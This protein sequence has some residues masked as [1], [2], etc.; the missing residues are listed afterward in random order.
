MLF[1]SALGLTV[2]ETY[3]VGNAS[4]L[5]SEAEA[6]APTMVFLTLGYVGLAA[7]VIAVGGATVSTGAGEILAVVTVAVNDI[8]KGHLK[9]DATDR[10]MLLLSR[11]GLFFI[12]GLV[13]AVVIYWRA[14]GFGFAGMYQA[15]GIAF[16]SAVIPLIMATFW[17]KTNRNAVFWATI[18]GSICGTTYWIHTDMDLLWGVVASNIIVMAVSALIAIPWTLIQI[19]RAHV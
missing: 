13:V 19:G 6:V 2:G 11:V 4:I 3:T 10:Q 9:K 17:T 8:V 12:A 15:M 7:F 18:V 14:I 5:F 1:R 16:S